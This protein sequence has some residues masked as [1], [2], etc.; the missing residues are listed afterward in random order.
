[1]LVSHGCGFTAPRIDDNQFATPGLDR[2]EALFDI[3]HGHDAAVGRQG[4]AAEDQHEIGMVNIRNRQQQAM[5]IHQVA[6]QVVR[7]LVDRGGGKSI[8]GLE[9]TEEVVAVGHQPVVVHAGVAL[10]HRHGVLPMGL[11]DGPELLRGQREGFVPANRLPAVACPLVRRAQP[12]RVV[13]DVLQGHGF[14]A[15]VAAAEAVQ[16]ITLDRI[17]AWL[18]TRLLSDFNGQATDGFTQVTGTVMQGLVHGHLLRV[19]GNPPN[20]EPERASRPASFAV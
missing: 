11:L 18:C 6:G 8:A 10:V 4:V 14:G 5:A 7:Q 12:V 3:R 19:S 15:D 16:G 1:M 13:L 17:D 9:Q 2:L 20:Y